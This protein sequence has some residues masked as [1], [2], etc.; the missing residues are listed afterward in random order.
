MMFATIVSYPPI[1]S[2]QSGDEALRLCSP[3]QGQEARP[4]PSL[5]EDDAGL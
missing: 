2:W 3:M 4:G 1:I 5:S